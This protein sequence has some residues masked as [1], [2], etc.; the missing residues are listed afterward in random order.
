MAPE[1][2]ICWSL[3]PCGMS[4]LIRHHRRGRP[5]VWRETPG[6]LLRVTGRQIIAQSVKRQ[7]T[8]GFGR[9][10]RGGAGLRG[11]RRFISGAPISRPALGRL[12]LC[13]TLA[14][15]GFRMIPEP[16]SFVTAQASSPKFRLGTQRQ[17]DRLVLVKSA[18][19]EAKK[20]AGARG[21][22]C[23]LWIGLPLLCR[24]APRGAAWHSR[25]HPFGPACTF[26]R[27][28]PKTARGCGGRG[29]HQG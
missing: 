19:L 16:V 1:R 8:G 6:V 25:T 21:W 9:G 29:D 13:R 28:N 18:P 26:A 14:H 11:R 7:V 12:G 5:V 2:R 24:Y 4:R 10:S 15:S 27:N 3:E 23:W 20:E 17:T 22:N